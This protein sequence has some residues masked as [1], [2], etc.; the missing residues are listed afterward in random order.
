MM[1]RISSAVFHVTARKFTFG[2]M[3]TQGVVF[4]ISFAAGA[5]LVILNK[6]FP[7]LKWLSDY[8]MAISMLIGMAAACIIF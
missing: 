2:Q 7:K 8:V 3:S 5:V 6:K 1:G 4:L